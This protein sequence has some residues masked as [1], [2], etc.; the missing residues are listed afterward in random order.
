[1]NEDGLHGADAI[2]MLMNGKTSSPYARAAL[3]LVTIP[4]VLS[5]NERVQLFQKLLDDA[6][7]QTGNTRDEFSRAL[8]VRM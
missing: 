4:Q 5:F 8:Q 6:K 3:I 7:A 1:M 2:Y